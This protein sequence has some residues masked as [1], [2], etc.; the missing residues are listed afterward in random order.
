[1]AGTYDGTAWRLY[2]NG[3]EIAVEPSTVGAVPVASDWAIGARAPGV[4]P[5]VPEPAERFFNGAI[6]DVRIYRRAL[7]A[8]EVEELAHH[9]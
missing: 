9:P 8:D 3:A 4:P 1:L 7:D 2:R 6:D 5:C